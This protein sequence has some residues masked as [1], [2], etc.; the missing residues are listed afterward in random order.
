M[1]VLEFSLGDLALSRRIILLPVGVLTKLSP[2]V[3]RGLVLELFCCI[4]DM[5]ENLLPWVCHQVKPLIKAD[6]KGVPVLSTFATVLWHLQRGRQ[7][8]LPAPT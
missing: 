5:V 2:A 7:K 4:K 8:S 1:Y 3:R 6:Y